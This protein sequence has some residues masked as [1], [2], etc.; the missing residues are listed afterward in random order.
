VTDDRIKQRIL[1]RRAQ[2]VLAALS[3]VACGEPQPPPQ[4]CLEPI[5]LPPE[6]SGA[7]TGAQI[8]PEP[9][10][11][12]VRPPEPVDSGVEDSGVQASVK[13]A[14]PKPTAVP[15]LSP[16]PPPKVCLKPMAPNVCLY[17]KK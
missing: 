16:M 5:M 7:D 17:L 13:D 3:A 14:G 8:P 4:I 2:L 9:C 10:L 11:Q 15:C 1:A 6:D 12:P